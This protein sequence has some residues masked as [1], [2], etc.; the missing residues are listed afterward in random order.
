VPDKREHRGP[1]PSDAALFAADRLASLREALADFSLLRS[2]GYADKSAMKLVGDRFALTQRQRLAV[3]RSACSDQQRQSRLSRRV[4]IGDL[5]GRTLAID[6]YNLLIT[7][8]AAMGGGLVFRGRDGCFRDLASIHG[9]YRRVEETIGALELIGAFLSEIDIAG[10]LWLLDSPVSNSGRLKTLIAD[11]AREHRWPWHVHLSL[12]PD[13]ELRGP[14]TV[15]SSQFPVPSKPST[16][17]CELPTANCD[18]PP[19]VVTTDSVILDACERW[20]NLAAEI[21]TRHLP[22]TPVIDLARS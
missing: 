20:T 1:H 18:L 7:I 14:L 22:E 2:K 10:A 15:H 13:A 16:D 9:T 6:G 11:L 3:M 8:E 17:D 21:I 4:E 19:I 12:N 5:G